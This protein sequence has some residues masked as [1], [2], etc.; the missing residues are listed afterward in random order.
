MPVPR[1]LHQFCLYCYSLWHSVSTSTSRWI[2][3]CLPCSGFI[4]RSENPKSSASNLSYLIIEGRPQSPH[5][6]PH[7]VPF[8][9]TIREIPFPVDLATLIIPP[10]AVV[11]CLVDCARAGVKGVVISS[12][13]FAETGSEG[14]RYQQKVKGSNLL[15]THCQN[16]LEPGVDLT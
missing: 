9:R 6:S 4:T 1:P 14:A 5:Q 2:S 15:L 16:M 3:Q 8:Y 13:G 12:E 11:P 10:K 7:G